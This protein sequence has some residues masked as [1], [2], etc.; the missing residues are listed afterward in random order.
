MA[1]ASGTATAILLRRYQDGDEHAATQLFEHL[2]GELHRLAA[3]YMCGERGGHVLQPTALINEAWLR[4]VHQ[5]ERDFADRDHFVAVAATVM[6]NVL[7]DFARRA[8]AKKRHSGAPVAPF[9]DALYVA[10]P[11]PDDS[12]ECEI[13]IVLL[14]SALARLTQLDERQAR[15]VELRYFGGLS[16]EEVA[17]LVGVSARTVKRDWTQAR[18]WLYGEIAAGRRAYESSRL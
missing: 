8:A 11:N 17:V 4:L 2:Y 14:D 9:E 15:I 18:A 6:R 7:V 13:D 1:F 10:A 5:Q 16:I 12:L 3:H